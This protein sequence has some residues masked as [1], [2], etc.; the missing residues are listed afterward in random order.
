MKT[1]MAVVALLG[2]MKYC[3]KP[4]VYTMPEQHTHREKLSSSINEDLASTDSLQKAL[5]EKFVQSI[6]TEYNSYHPDSASMAELKLRWNDSLSVKVIGGNWC[7]DTRQQLP[8]LCN[9]LDAIGANAESFGYYKVNKD[10]K[11]LSNDFAAKHEVNRVPTAFIFK[12]GKLLGEI[13]ETP[14]KS[15]ENHLLEIIKSGY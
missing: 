5:A 9:V 6:A 4:K 14:K 3:T 15:W 11:A 13:V 2:T 12:D 7:S 8:R 10:K 1:L